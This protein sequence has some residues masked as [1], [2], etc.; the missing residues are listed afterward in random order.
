MNEPIKCDRCGSLTYSPTYRRGGNFCENCID[1]CTVCHNP[2]ELS[3]LRDSGICVFCESEAEHQWQVRQ[4][5][6]GK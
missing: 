4:L 5:R 2:R 3:E 1:F 6:K